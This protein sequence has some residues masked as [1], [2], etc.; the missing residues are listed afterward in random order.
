[1]NL[2]VLSRIYPK[3]YSIYNGVFVQSQVRAL[4]K[5]INGD[6]TVISPVPWS[7]RLLWFNKKW[8][9]YGNTEKERAEEGIKVYYPRYFAI[10]GNLFSL[11]QGFFIYCSIR[12]MVRRIINMQMG[13]DTILH[14][15][16]ILPDGMAGVFLAKELKIPHICTIHGSDINIQPFKSKMNFILTKF[17]LKRCDYIVSV[18]MGLKDKV[19]TI[20]SE[21]QHISVINN[22]ADPEKFRPLSKKIAMQ[23]LN[24]KLSQKVIVFVGN[25][26]PVKGVNFLIQAFAEL[27]KEQEGDK[28]RLLLIGE[29][30]GRNEICDLIK[31]LNKEKSILLLGKRSHDE[32]PLWLNI[33][34]IFVLPSI[35]EGFPTVIPEALMCGVPVL[36]TDVGGIP[37][38]M[39]NGKT[40][41]LVEARNAGLLK[42][43]MRILLDD[44][45]LRQKISNNAKHISRKYTW[46]NNALGYLQIYNNLLKIA[47]RHG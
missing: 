1:M 43:K 12:S 36:A 34:D 10:P 45:A 21:I 32:I 3:N 40:G 4:K 2:I 23:K 31:S 33:A 25:L 24:M 22:G 41:F 8:R 13:R 5:L 9:D 7:P 38:I 37:E 47:E 29:G 35:S 6:I 42:E 19:H 14:T 17:A 44:D 15:H 30:S 26:I 18:S 28:L 27:Q 20:A 46:D 11:L 39:I 16:T